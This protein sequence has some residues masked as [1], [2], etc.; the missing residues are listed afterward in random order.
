[1]IDQVPGRHCILGK[2]GKRDVEGMLLAEDAAFH[3]KAASKFFSAGLSDTL[4]LGMLGEMES[5]AQPVRRYL[6]LHD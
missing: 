6:Q 2:I 1:M 4:A 3:R 5:G